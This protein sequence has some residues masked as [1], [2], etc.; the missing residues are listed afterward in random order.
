MQKFVEK[1]LANFKDQ[2]LNIFDIGSQNVTEFPEGSYKP[3][4]ENS[5]WEYKGVDIVAGNNV[6][7][8]V[9]DIYNWK[10]IKSA[11]ANVVISGQ[12]FEH[13][14]YTWA[15][16]LEITRILK[17]N[18]LLCLVVPSSGPEHKY[19]ID[20]WRFFPDG[21]KSLAKY[22]NLEVIE[23]YNCWNNP[24]IDGEINEWKDSV[25]ICKKQNF[26]FW[27]NLKFTLKRF[28]QKIILK[29]N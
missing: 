2:N 15:T 25:L 22:A 16:M 10:E 7:V 14:E 1:Y 18:G 27:Q 9:S 5:K 17:N 3:L 20:C 19:P 12:A 21:L 13:I 11:S 28:L 26:S 8:V 29:L 23:S 6:D 24:P 4:F